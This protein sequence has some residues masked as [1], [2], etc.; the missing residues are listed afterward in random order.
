MKG[1]AGFIGEAALSVILVL[2]WI[3]NAF[4]GIVSGIWLAIIGEWLAI[5]LGFAMS[6]SM[7][8]AYTLVTLPSL[9]LMA[10]VIPAAGDGQTDK[11]F[12][13]GSIA[14]LYES[15]VI[16]A[17]AG[18]VCLVF[19]FGA[20]SGSLIPRLIWAY[21]TTMSPLAY[22]ASHESL[23]DPGAAK[24]L[25]LGQLG[26]IACLV[27]FLCDAFWPWVIP[28]LVGLAVLNMVFTMYM[29][30]MVLAGMREERE[31]KMLLEQER[32]QEGWARDWYGP[33]GD[34]LRHEGVAQADWEEDLDQEDHRF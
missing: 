6:L 2:V 16:V 17:W 34:R 11:V 9:G 13:L 5:G 26:Y 21:A 1:L 30:Y 24:G 4:G 33:P 22:M 32:S 7:P 10:V 23:D 18:I 20:E 27:L 25:V 31:Y 3:A 29:M 14:S 28:S 15:C 8:Y 12:V 19:V